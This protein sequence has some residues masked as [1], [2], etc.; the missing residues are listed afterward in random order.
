MLKLCSTGKFINDRCLESIETAKLLKSLFEVIKPPD[1]DTELIIEEPL[2][3]LFGDIQRVE[4]AFM[5]ILVNAM[6][7]RNPENPKTIITVDGIREDGRATVN[8]RDNGKGIKKETLSRI[9]LPGFTATPGGTGFGLPI[10]KK[11]VESHGGKVTAAS[12]G[13]GK[14]A[15][16]TIQMPAGEGCAQPSPA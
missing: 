13:E 10:V 4:E 15:V 14:G 16:F 11:I 7:N 3:N 8:F 6:K 12:E 2:P 1:D 5:N 9:F